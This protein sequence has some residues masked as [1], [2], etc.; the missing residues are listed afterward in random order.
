MSIHEMQKAVNAAEKGKK[1]AALTP[2]PNRPKSDQNP[3]VAPND[4]QSIKAAA[5]AERDPSKK[6]DLLGKLSARLLSDMEAEKDAVK[7]TDLR[8]E[9]QT[10]EKQRAYALLADRTASPNN[11]RVRKLVDMASAD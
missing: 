4:I 11:A 10:A 8:R 3:I 6:A 5:K 1:P 2:K 7:Q 9:Y